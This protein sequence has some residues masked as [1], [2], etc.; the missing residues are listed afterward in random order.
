MAPLTSQSRTKCG[1]VLTAGGFTA[2]QDDVYGTFAAGGGASDSVADLQQHSPASPSSNRRTLLR[3]AGR[4]YETA[5]Y[6]AK[7]FEAFGLNASIKTYYTLLSKPVSRSLAIVSPK[8][9]AREIDLSEGVV[10]GDACTSNKD[11]LPPFLAYAASGNVTAS[12]VYANMG[13]PEDFAW[14][15]AQNVTLKGKIALVRYGGNFRGL[16]V[17]AAEQHSMAGVL[18]YSDPQDDGFVQGPAYPKGPWRPEDSFQRGSLQYLSL[19]GGDPLTPGWPSTLGAEYLK[20]EDVTS[21]PHIP[22]LPLS[23]G[24]ARHILKALGGTKAPDAWQGGLKLRGGY[25]LGDNAATVLTLNLV[26]DNSVGPI[27]DAVG[28]I[29]GVEEP[30]QQVLIG[31]HR[32]AW[33]CGAVDPNSGSAVMLEVARNLGALL[34]TGWRPRRSL[35]L[36]SWDGEEYGLLGSTEYAEENAEAL[37]THAVAYLNVDSILGPLVS[38]GGTPSIAAFLYETA[39]A[40]PANR[41]FGNE[42]EATLY[43]QWANQAAVRRARQGGATTG[44]LAPDYLVAFMGSGSDYTAFYQHLGVISANLAF[45]LS[46]HPYGVYHSSMDSV[47][48]YE[49]FADPHYETQATTARWWGLLALRLASAPLVP[50]DFSTYGAAMT[51]VLATFEAR[52]AARGQPVDLAP[53]HRAIASFTAAAQLLRVTTEAVAKDAAPPDALRRALNDKLVRL[54]RFLLADAGLP[55]RPWYKHV[56]FGP[57]FYEGYSGAAF[58]GI[59]DAL[60]FGDNATVIQAHVDDVARVVQRAADF[61]SL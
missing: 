60:A 54:E 2:G 50:F 35:V 11:A 14:L 47:P 19:A 20:Y 30:E 21:I 25:H 40:I 34:K 36:G 23:Y 9:H 29:D 13:R 10:K 33:V 28:T 51:D 15:A 58:P 57:G 41:F 24:Q 61:L 55:H 38:A 53:L 17:M 1:P 48:Y 4:D 27:W 12:V 39:K 32:D 31:N 42:T 6:T 49:Q 18:I 43:E 45:G 26:M 37:K 5:V 46:D 3:A 16:K 22:A 7:Q 8:S 44:L 59:D 52:F 56:I